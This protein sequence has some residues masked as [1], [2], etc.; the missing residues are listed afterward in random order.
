VTD[1][2]GFL[3][4]AALATGAVLPALTR[5][6]DSAVRVDARNAVLIRVFQLV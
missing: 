4:L 5:A 6:A 2:R 1:R 3:G